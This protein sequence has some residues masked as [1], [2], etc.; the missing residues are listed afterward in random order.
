M[1]GRIWLFSAVLA[2]LVATQA[3]AQD[4]GEYLPKA[5][6]FRIGFSTEGGSGLS[7]TDLDSLKTTNISFG[8]SYFF[9]SNFALEL[10]FSY[11]ESRFVIFDG[12]EFFEEE[13][14]FTPKTTSF[15]VGVS[16]YLGSG[17]TSNFVPFLSAS[18]ARIDTDGPTLTGFNASLGG[19]LFLS[20]NTSLDISV[21]YLNLRGGGAKADGFRFGVG[22]SVWFR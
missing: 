7:Y 18:Y 5:G 13:F 15:S 10:G 11:A 21:S 4:N 16:F 6:D 22:F 14:E 17:G 20:Q 8:G 3:T 1:Q 2:C 12:G 9:S 19:H